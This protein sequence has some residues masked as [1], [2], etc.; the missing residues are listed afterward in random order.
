MQCPNC[1]KELKDG[2]LY[3]EYCGYEIQM[4]PNFEP[5]VE[6]SILSS[7]KD[8]QKEVDIASKEEAD[9]AREEK[10]K[11]ESL[12]YR[13]KEFKKEHKMIF[14]IFSAFCVS[15]CAL[16]VIGIIALICYLSPGYQYGKAMEA[17]EK[18]N[19]SECLTYVERTVLL[20]ESYVDAYIAGFQ[21]AL[22]LEDYSSAEKYLVDGI[23]Y[24]AYDESEI[25]Y[26]YD[27]LIQKYID[28]KQYR[29]INDLLI[30]CPSSII[31]TKYQDYL[32]LPVKFSYAEGTYVE[33]IPLKL[34]ATE[35]GNIYYTTDG[36]VPTTE[37]AKYESPI[38]LEVGKYVIN[39]IFINDYGVES[40]VVTKTFYVENRTTPYPPSVSV[41]SGE[42]VIPEMITIDYSEGCS[43][44]YTTDGSTP[45]KSSTKYTG[46]IPMP[47]GKTQFKFVCYNDESGFP[48]EVVSRDY[49]L[50]LNTEYEFTNAQRDV[51]ALM[52]NANVILDYSGTCS[53]FDGNNSYEY[54]YAISEEGMGEFY[55]IA[56]YHQSPETEKYATGNLFA[57]NVYDGTIYKAEIT[58]NM[59]YVLTLYE[60]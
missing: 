30:F 22:I 60:A 32:S 55:I 47:L 7:L 25:V 40:E 17:Y 43:V 27:E 9:K 6:G 13:I 20:D 46:A 45:D 8:I 42:Y 5:E 28:T 29:K 44:Y 1:N 48:S 57:V 2:Y 53:N 37:S 14:Y 31:V 34:S 26:C 18:K 21:S 59:D 52:I 54:Q 24:G 15:F 58:E 10:E 49:T 41:Y 51:Y 38:F 12:F 39:A 23:S 4:V 3:C 16:F 19:Y 35:N 33:T 11:H 56:E 50:T 36:S